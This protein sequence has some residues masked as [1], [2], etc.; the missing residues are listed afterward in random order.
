MV[1]KTND[2]FLYEMKHC[3]WMGYNS[4]YLQYQPVDQLLYDGR[5]LLLNGLSENWCNFFFKYIILLV[6][7]LMKASVVS[8]KPEINTK[9]FFQGP[10]Y[11]D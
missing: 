7:Y 11:R 6:P 10:K 4:I 8:I 5:A 1:C 3:G 2:W 9:M